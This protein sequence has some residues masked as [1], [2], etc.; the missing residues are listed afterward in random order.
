MA[1]FLHNNVL[2]NG[3]N[4]ITSN[5]TTLYICSALPSTYAEAS[6]TYKLGTKSS[7]TV[8]APANG[9]PNGRSVTVSAITD[10]TVNTT[11]TA[12]H[13]A[14]TSGSVLI[15]AGQL[16]S[17]QAVTAGNTFTLSAITINIPAAV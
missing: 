4:Y 9:S 11:G 15:A 5:T 10:G 17:S 3:L 16:A 12:T 14:L 13:Y 8:S 1:S 6:S 2:D 7:P